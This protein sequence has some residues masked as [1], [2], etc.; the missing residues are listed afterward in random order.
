VVPEAIMRVLVTGGTGFIGSH[1]VAALS[2][3]GH[4]VRVLVRSPHKLANLYREHEVPLCGYVQGDMTDPGAVSEALEDCDGV[5]HAAALVA[6]ERSRAQEVIE[7]NLRGV[8][9]VLGPAHARGIRRIVYV[10]STAALFDPERGPMTADH[11]VAPHAAS[12]YGLS[13]AQGELFVRGLQ[14]AG[15]CV[16]TTYP[17]SVLGPNDPELSEGNQ[18][19]QFMLQG[20]R[21][22]TEGGMHVVDVR[23]LAAIHVA[24]LEAEPRPARYVAAGPF[25]TWREIADLLDE[26]T[27][28]WAPRMPVDARMLRFAG[29]IGDELKRWLPLDAPLTAEGMEYA[30]RWPGADSSKTLSELGLEFRSPRATFEDTLR[31]LYRSGHVEP[32]YVGRLARD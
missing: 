20:P 25:L 17:A 23:D 24:L 12:A 26:V 21:M 10:S 22:L 27:G 6:L 4:E 19:L 28:R 9:L 5:V 29:R 7:T 2:R 3:A 15:V 8:E 11:P 30:T 18:G 32:R 14:A 31:W 13:K 1:T 16:R